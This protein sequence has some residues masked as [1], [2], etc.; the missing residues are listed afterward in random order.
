ML[1]LW[2]AAASLTF[3]R[4]HLVFRCP[5]PHSLPH[6]SFPVCSPPSRF[7]A[8]FYLFN[9]SSCSCFCHL[10]FSRLL[11]VFPLIQYRT[12]ASSPFSFS[13]FAPFSFLFIA[14]PRSF[15]LHLFNLNFLSPPL[16]PLH[17]I[18]LPLSVLLCYFSI[19][20]RPPPPLPAAFSTATLWL[21]NYAL[22]SPGSGRTAP[23]WPWPTCSSRRGPSRR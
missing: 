17:L 4:Q 6:I 16:L 11:W 10:F 15:S 5:S 19:S 22:I 14:P 8:C 23:R 20:L 1:V 9:N 3:L 21:F 12:A 7:S 13:L 2:P 18:H